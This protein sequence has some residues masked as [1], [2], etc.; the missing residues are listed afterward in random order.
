[1]PSVRYH[2]GR[3]PPESLAWESLIPLI[4]PAYAAVAR[5]DGMLSS[6]PSPDLLLAPLITR[7][8]VLSSRIEGTQAT[9]GEVLEFEAVREASSPERRNDIFEV[10][11]YRAAMH[12]AEGLLASIPLSQRLIRKAHEVLMSDVR[13]RSKSPG[14]YRRIQNWIGPPGCSID[15]ATFVPISAELLPDAMSDWEKFVHSEFMDRLVQMAILHA[16]TTFFVASWY[17]TEADVLH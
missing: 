5:Y 14:E 11:N 4:G 15:E 8:A 2:T 16:G 9:L 3:F 10:L 7:E 6:I 13:G 17:Y 12:E 1:M